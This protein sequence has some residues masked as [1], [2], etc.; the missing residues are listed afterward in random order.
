MKASGDNGNVTWR[1]R[2]GDLSWREIDEEVIIL[3]LRSATYLK[4]NPAGAVLWKRLEPGATLGQLTV[5][6]AE[7]FGLVSEVAHGDAAA[8]LEVCASKGIVERLNA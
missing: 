3:D 4:L 1:Q 5:T 2:G 8:F 6:L 7:Q